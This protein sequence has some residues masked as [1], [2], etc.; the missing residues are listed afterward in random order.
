MNPLNIGVIGRGCGGRVIVPLAKSSTKLRVV[1]AADPDPAAAE[2]AR[3][4]TVPLAKSYED[5]LGNPEV[6][7]VVL[8][9]P[10]TLHT[11]Q[12]ER[13]ANAGKHVF[14]EKLLSLSRKEVIRAVEACNQNNVKLAVGHEKRFEPPIQELMRMAKSGELEALL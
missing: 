9:T 3:Q 8:C 10:H 7:A 2:F 13:A 4:Q 12:I 5:V 11:D 1:A 14:C 6:Q